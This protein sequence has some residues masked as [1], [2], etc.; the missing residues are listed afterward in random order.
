MSDV[1]H[2]PDELHAVEELHRLGCTDGLPVI[3]P[4]RDRVDR[5]VLATGLDAGDV[6]GE[7][8]PLMGA[9]TV[10]KVAIA[11]VM[12]GCLP[13]HVPVVVA[14]IRAMCQPEF[15]LREMQATTH[16]TAP[17]LIVNGPARHACGGL[18]SGFGVMGPGHRP[19]AAIGRAVRLAM[20]NIGGA[21]PGESDMA[22]H[23]H[24]GKFTFCIAE[25][26]EGSP[27]P[28]LH[29]TF[30]YEPDQSVVT[31]VGAEAPHSAFFIGDADDPHG[32]AEELLGVLASMIAAPGTNNVV[33]GGAGAVIVV[34]NPDHTAVL[35]AVGYDRA[36]VQ[37][38][39]AEL[40][41]L[42]I[43]AA[44][45]LHPRQFANFKGS[46][47]R[48]IRDPQQVILV[49][50]GGTGLYSMVMPTW[51]AGAHHNQA[52]HA[53]IELDQACEVPWANAEQS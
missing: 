39:I 49:Q 9:A 34:L 6:L 53:E 52:V 25:D 5:M 11:A 51:C 44:R 48:A 20:I 30:G 29:T 4:T 22:L 23:G 1:L 26:E 10:E 45:R 12:A 18:A 2:A 40:A 46:E 36:K 27:F 47:V 14:A 28:P 41:V 43:E 7:M 21:R 16:C 19:N 32:S 24:P 42:P 3:V 17:L 37:E 33:L 15:D 31:V 35:A 8:G 38:R 50:A 13:D